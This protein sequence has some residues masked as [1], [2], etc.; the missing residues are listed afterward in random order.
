MNVTYFIPNPKGSGTPT[1]NANQEILM[2]KREK[3]G[4]IIPKGETCKPSQVMAIEEFNVIKKIL[5]ME[6]LLPAGYQMVQSV[7]DTRM[8]YQLILF[9]CLLL[10]HLK[11]KKGSKKEKHE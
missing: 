1:N 9:L 8:T 7:Q 11:I 3:K 2:V 4:I 10:S 6:N 5:G